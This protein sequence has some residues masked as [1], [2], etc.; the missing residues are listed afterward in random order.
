MTEERVVTPYAKGDLVDQR[1][2]VEDLMPQGGMGR[3]YEVFDTD[4]ER[5]VA[6]KMLLVDNGENRKRFMAEARAAAGVTS[7]HVISVFDVRRCTDVGREEIPYFTMHLLQ[8]E[9]LSVRLKQGPITRETALQWALQVARGLAAAH[10][11]GVTHRDL[12]PANIFVT[13]KGEVILLDFGLAKVRPEFRSSDATQSFL[14][15][16]GTVL[17]TI[18]YMSPEQAAGRE[19]DH[20]SDIFSFG[21]VLYELVTGQQAFRG[22]NTMET[23]SAVLEAA[24]ERPSSVSVSISPELDK[25]ILRC[26]AKDLH[27]RFQSAS[28]IESEVSVL[29]EEASRRA[30]APV[31]GSQQMVY[32]EDEV[33]SVGREFAKGGAGI[34]YWFNVPLGSVC[35]DRGFGEH[36]QPAL[37]N[38]DIR[39]LRFILDDD[40]F[41][42]RLWAK[43]VLPAIARWAK[44]SETPDGETDGVLQLEKKKV[45]WLYDERV[46][47]ATPCKLFVG[48]RIDTETQAQIYLATHHID[49]PKEATEATGK[50]ETQRAPVASKWWL[51]RFFEGSKEGL[52]AVGVANRPARGATGKQETQRPAAIL[53]VHPRTYP[54]LMRVLVAEIVRRRE[55]DWR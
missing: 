31:G 19:V 41:I 18:A 5:R 43:A 52:E 54:D 55:A 30:S 3:V 25:L 35:F 33:E 24:P 17:G 20:R 26:L 40:T 22:S 37:Q 2:R 1:Y 46:G 36:L 12:K 29:I 39:E 32:I 15:Q 51:R 23:L 42:K 34:M 13:H 4:L 45:Q 11:K 16:Q 6:L 50:Q 9:P 7:S 47:R 27:R 8:G 44:L 49:P 10:A 28:E 48:R 14:T 21:A 38:D 53:W